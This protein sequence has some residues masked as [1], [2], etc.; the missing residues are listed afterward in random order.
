MKRWRIALLLF[1]LSGIGTG[2]YVLQY[3]LDAAL[4]TRLAS[5]PLPSFKQE[6]F[7]LFVRDIYLDTVNHPEWGHLVSTM[8][9]NS[10][11]SKNW[12]AI[13]YNSDNVPTYAEWCF[14]TERG[15][16]AA[17]YSYNGQAFVFDRITQFSW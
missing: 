12:I 16:R 15:G 13:F 8:Y 2:Y 4:N 10:L 6:P 1:V 9:Y 7:K 3:R 17:G 11:E 14:D 5:T